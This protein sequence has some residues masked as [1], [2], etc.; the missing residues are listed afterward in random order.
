MHLILNLPCLQFNEQFL[1]FFKK[2]AILIRLMKEIFE[3]YLEKAGII[4]PKENKGDK[5]M[6]VNEQ[7]LHLRDRFIQYSYPLTP[8][9][10]STFDKT[11]RTENNFNSFATTGVNAEIPLS[12]TSE[13]FGAYS[14][15]KETSGKIKLG[16]L[17]VILLIVSSALLIYGLTR[18]IG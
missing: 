2:K 15:E 4:S 17:F 10:Q 11:V 12:Q 8:S 16:Y 14:S 9:S 1:D 13:N 18:L 5:K 6:A 7:E 3:K